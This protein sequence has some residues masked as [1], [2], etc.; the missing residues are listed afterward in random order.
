MLSSLPTSLI[1]TT[2]RCCSSWG[3]SRVSDGRGARPKVWNSSFRNPSN[4][5]PRGLGSTR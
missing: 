1:Y 3:G 5:I 4:A 2:S